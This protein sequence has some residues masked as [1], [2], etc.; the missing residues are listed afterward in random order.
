ASAPAAT[1]RCAAEALPSRKDPRPASVSM[2]TPHPGTAQP[3]RSSPAGVGTLHPGLRRCSTAAQILCSKEYP[4]RSSLP[5]RSDLIDAVRTLLHHGQRDTAVVGAGTGCHH[6]LQHPVRDVLVAHDGDFTAG[7]VVFRFLPKHT[8]VLRHQRL[9][10]RGY[11]VAGLL[12]HVGHFGHLQSLYENIFVT[13][14]YDDGLL[15]FFL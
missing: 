11:V 3:R 10:Q 5:Y 15:C 1:W 6:L 13:D 9:S 12:Q 14:Q 7:D 2:A 4:I 8:F